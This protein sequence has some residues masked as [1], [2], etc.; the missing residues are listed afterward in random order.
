MSA[1]FPSATSNRR[2]DT[3][4]AT[5]VPLGTNT[6]AVILWAAWETGAASGSATTAL[7]CLG[8]GTTPVLR[9]IGG[10]GE[11]WR[12]QAT[13]GSRMDAPVSFT[14]EQWYR[15]ALWHGP[16]SGGS[17]TAR[18]YIDSETP[19][20]RSSTT[21]G[22]WPDFTRLRLGQN[23]AENNIFSNFRGWIA[24]VAFFNN[25]SQAN[26]ETV[27]SEALTT[28]ATSWSIAPNRYWPLFDDALADIGSDDFSTTGTVDF[29]TSFHPDIYSAPP[30]A[31]ARNRM[32]WW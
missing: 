22:T 25:I 13:I 1:I 3:T 31:T 7:D 16:D 12:A 15:L 5:P 29:S 11:E 19:L 20:T 28:P 4:F 30:A 26:F 9:I 18:F 8:T 24:E 23:Y 14:S 10:T 17:E 27:I 32:M 6:P 21:P 2:L